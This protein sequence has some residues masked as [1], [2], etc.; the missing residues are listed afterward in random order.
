MMFVRLILSLV[1]VGAALS[2]DARDWPEFRGPTGQGHSE[3][4]IPLEWS[5]ERNIAWKVP[6]PGR[7]WSSPV[8]SDGT[9]WL[10]TAVAGDAEASLR[11]LAFDSETG[12]RTLDVEVF[13][14]DD[15]ELLNLK[16]SH[17]SPT[18]VV[19]AGRV[20]V[21]FGPYGTAA[22]TTG[23]EVLW[24]TRLSYVPQHGNGG[25]PIVHD[26]M[27]IINCDGFDRSFVVALDAE[28]GDQ[29]WRTDRRE[30]SSQAYSTPLVIRVGG[31]DQ[32]ISVG[33]FQTVALDPE[34]GDEV[35]RVEYPDD[36]F[37]TV[38]RPV[39]GHGLVFVVT[40]FNQPSLLAIRPDGNGNVTDTHVEWTRGQSV[41]LTPSPLLVGDEIYTISDIGVISCLDA[42]TGE[43]HW[44]GR[45]AGNYSASPL[46]AGG[47]IY[48]QSEEGMTTVIRPGTAFEVVGTN[49]VEGT[50]LAS[51]AVDDGAAFLRSSSDLYRIGGM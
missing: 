14:L 40:G 16:N 50:T 35:W 9:I 6:V 43:E 24:T 8:I 39:Y 15:A 28:T 19:T 48:F 42:R 33:A 49:R 23:G 47:H 3:E 27:V 18:P 44:R 30:P 21:H 31:R 51:M 32:I 7:G 10:T 1:L 13:R 17:A 12:N 38:P 5:E 46:Y 37:S 45:V 4:A 36:G 25:S 26:G 20:Y 22:L 11:V 29:R 41:P 34:S 2:A